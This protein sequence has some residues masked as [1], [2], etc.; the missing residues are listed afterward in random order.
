MLG[1]VV[2]YHCCGDYRSSTTHPPL[3]RHQLASTRTTVQLM[4]LDTLTGWLAS[5]PAAGATDPV[6]DGYSG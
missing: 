5:Y 3:A 1:L 2:Y 6:R 4:L